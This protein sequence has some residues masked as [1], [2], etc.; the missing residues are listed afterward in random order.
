M[1]ANQTCLI[2]QPVENINENIFSD[3]LSN[4][5][6]VKKFK[7]RFYSRWFRKLRERMKKKIKESLFC[8]FSNDPLLGIKYY[9]YQMPI[10]TKS[11]HKLV[12]IYNNFNEQ[13][14]SEKRKMKARNVTNVKAIIEYQNMEIELKG[15]NDDYTLY[16]TLHPYAIKNISLI[17]KD[18]NYHCCICLD[19]NRSAL[20]SLIYNCGHIMCIKC[21]ATKISVYSNLS[22]IKVF[23]SCHY[24][25]S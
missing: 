20:K 10:T 7:L 1:R 16:H 22:P 21:V 15:K 19:D 12:P 25:C 5:P 18:V 4:S 11:L 17:F 24:K 23:E 3:Y 6:N 14:Y 2:Q 9:N 13:M 8:M